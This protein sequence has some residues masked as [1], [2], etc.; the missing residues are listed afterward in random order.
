MFNQTSLK[1]VIRQCLTL[2]TQSSNKTI[3]LVLLTIIFW[4]L[5]KVLN[6]KIILLHECHPMRSTTQ[7][8]SGRASR[9]GCFHCCNVIVGSPENR[10]PSLLAHTHVLFLPAS[11]AQVPQGHGEKLLLPWS[12][13]HAAAEA[14]HQALQ[15]AARLSGVLKSSERIKKPNMMIAREA[16]GGFSCRNTWSQTKRIVVWRFC[17]PK[18]VS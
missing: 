18:L 11:P 6:M 12:Q 17:R 7:F 10:F 13:T 4:Y 8:R 9:L 15:L 14:L 16:D 5:F 2:L 3:C 1:N